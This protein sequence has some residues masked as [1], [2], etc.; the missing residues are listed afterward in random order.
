MRAGVHE[1]TSEM[2]RTKIVLRRVAV[3][4]GAMHLSGALLLLTLLV[5]PAWAL[6]AYGVAPADNPSADVPPFLILLAALIGF[7]GFHVVVQIPS[8]LLG[9]CLGRKR[10]FLVSYAFVMAVAGGL[11]VV[12]LWGV[13]GVG[14]AAEFWPLWADCMARGSVALAGYVWLSR[15]WARPARGPQLGLER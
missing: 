4:L 8:G 1:P 13:L 3:H 2:S 15:L 9:T 10:R 12:F 14:R 11:T 5:P 6:D 7:M